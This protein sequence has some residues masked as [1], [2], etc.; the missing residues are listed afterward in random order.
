VDPR[1]FWEPTAFTFVRPDLVVYIRSHFLVVKANI[2]IEKGSEVF[3]NYGKLPNEML[4]YGYAYVEEHNVDDGVAVKMMTASSGSKLDHGKAIGLF[5][6]E[7]G[8]LSGIPK[9]SSLTVNQSS[10]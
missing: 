6:I 8:G 7:P 10:G 5:Y 2:D 3:Y 4:L 1:P 9:V